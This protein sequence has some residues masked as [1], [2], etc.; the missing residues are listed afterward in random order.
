MSYAVLFG[1]N[2]A[3][4]NGLSASAAANREIGSKV[5]LAT[6]ILYALL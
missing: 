4:I 3:D 1:T 5:V 2:N 6:R